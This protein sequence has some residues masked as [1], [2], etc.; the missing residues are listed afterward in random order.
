MPDSTTTKSPYY[1]IFD[2]HN[3]VLLSL[4]MPE[5]GK[6]RSFFEESEIGHLDLPRAKKGGFA[7]GFF[8]IFIPNPDLEKPPTDDDDDDDD[9][10][11]KEKFDWVK[12]R[13]EGTIPLPDPLDF[14]Y[15]QTKA[16]DLADLLFNLEKQSNN[17]FQVVTTTTQ[18][19]NN[20]KNNI[21]SA[22]LHLEG[23]EPIAPD[24]SNLITWYDRGLRSIGLVWSR[25]NA[26]AH[27][28]PFHCPASPETGP[29]L[30]EAGKELVHACNELGIMIDLSHLNQNG[31]RDVANISKK[32]L[33]ATH[34]CAHAVCPSARN[35]TDQQ[36]DLI[37]QSNGLVGCNFFVGDVRPDG[38][39][40]KEGGLAYQLQQINYLVDKMGIEHVAFGSDFDGATMPDELKDAAHYPNLIA[41]LQNAGYTNDQLSLLTHRNFLR[42][43]NETWNS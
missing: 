42:I 2:G 26:F 14:D 20:I 17:Q 7:A 9:D 43:L 5:H 25:P 22:I 29:G 27:G 11:D 38:G 32:P 4:A 16:N 15:A 34:S 23:A 41:E 6:N 37:K 36:L 35:L 21:V 28:V 30:T 24:L 12:A 1:P 3:D 33:V 8:A 10:N 39:M 13:R 40:N 31:V 19:E 18:I